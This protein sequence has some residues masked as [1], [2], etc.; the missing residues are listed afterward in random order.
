MNKQEF[1][2]SIKEVVVND[3]IKSVESNLIRP[4]GRAPEEKLNTLSKW[5]NN[6]NDADRNMVMQVVKESV[7][8]SVFGFLCVLD[9]V[10]AIEDGE[11]KGKLDLYYEKDEKLT[12]LN[13]QSDEYLHDLL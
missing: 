8:T 7:Q 5:F 1:I 11:E 3:S 9:G 4:P 10:R 2:N 12:L 13:N 6:L